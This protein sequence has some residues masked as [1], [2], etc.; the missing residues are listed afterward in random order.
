[1]PYAAIVRVVGMALTPS[2]VNVTS[3]W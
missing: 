2:F 3:Y 1:V